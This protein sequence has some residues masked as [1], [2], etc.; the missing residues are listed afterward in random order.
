MAIFKA[1]PTTKKLSAWLTSPGRVHRGW[2]DNQGIHPTRGATVFY[3]NP[4]KPV[5]WRAFAPDLRRRK[6]GT[7]ANLEEGKKAAMDALYDLTGR[8]WD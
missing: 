7:A 4:S 8:R 2:V 3:G 1:L 6:K 5:E